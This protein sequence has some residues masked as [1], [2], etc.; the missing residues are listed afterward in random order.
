MKFYDV[1]VHTCV[2]ML[3]IGGYPVTKRFFVKASSEADAVRK[4]QE[5]FKGPIESIE[6]R[7]STTIFVE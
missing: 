7:P 1:Y 6:C 2:G 3:F 4:V 5:T